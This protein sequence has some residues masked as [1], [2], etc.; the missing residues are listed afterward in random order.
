[1]E[2]YFGWAGVDGHFLCVGKGEW[3]IFMAGWGL[4][5]LYF[6]WMG[7]GGHLLWVG[8]GRWR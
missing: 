5:E 6:A 4:V 3:T 1:M 2:V 7:V 8:G